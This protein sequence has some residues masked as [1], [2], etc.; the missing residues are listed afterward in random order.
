MI[1]S[2]TLLTACSNPKGIKFDTFYDC[3][4]WPKPINI[5]MQSGVAK[6]IT[7]AHNSYKQCKAN[8]E[9]LRELNGK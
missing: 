4:D 7:K 8:L 3:P 2:L 5:E 1:F 6:Y 9:A